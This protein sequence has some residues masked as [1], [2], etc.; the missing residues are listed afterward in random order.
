[1]E[2]LKIEDCKHRWLYKLDSRNLSHG[3]YN[4]ADKSFIGIRHKFGSNFLDSEYHYDTGAPHG[5]AMPLEVICE[6]PAEISDKESLGTFEAVTNKPLVWHSI[7]S[8]WVYKGT[9]MRVET[10]AVSKSNK[11][12][13]AWLQAY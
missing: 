9:E 11:D 8:C 13:F 3:V 7:M 1:M 12:L 2:Y 6:L 4:E 5:T 10:Y